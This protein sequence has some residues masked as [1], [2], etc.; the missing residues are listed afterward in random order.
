MAS[1]VLFL[2]SHHGSEHLFTRGLRSGAAACGREPHVLFLRDAAGAARPTAALRDEL[3]ALRPER[4]AFLMDAPLAWGDL[5]DDPCLAALPK[6]SLWYDDF[7]RC[8][9]TTAPEGAALWRRWHAERNVTVFFHDGHWRGAWER[10]I[11]FPARP[12]D[13]SAD[14]ALV[15]GSAG[16]ASPYPELSR[17]AVMLGTIPARAP[18][19]AKLASFPPPVAAWIAASAAAMETAPWPFRAYALADTLALDLPPKQR[20]VLEKWLA[21]PSARALA[22]YEIWRWGK[23]AARLRGLRALARRVPT[24]VLS[25]HR[26]EVFAREEEL[27]AALGTEADFAFR[28]TTE[29]P[30]A[31]WAGLF[32]TGTLQ[33]QWLDP[34]SIESGAPFRMFEAAAA[35]VPLLTD[36]RPGFPALF[37]EGELFYADDEAALADRAAAL[38]PQ[39]DRL[40][41]AGEQALATF[42]ARHTWADRW[43]AIEAATA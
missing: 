4:I 17:H 38:L 31:H 34:Q 14:A 28:D 21:A 16:A 12:T 22:R 9:A 43:R 36:A 1:R 27:R 20:L 32:R 39:R 6:A 33:V 10:E 24:A 11:G 3:A 37:P 40:R 23:R 19:E 26:T 7:Y 29:V 35:G 15:S 30:A 41:A 42:A 25:G 2:E 5:W 13:L 18:L 8:P